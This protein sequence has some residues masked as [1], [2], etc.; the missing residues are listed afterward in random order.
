VP[1]PERSAP[2]HLLV[3]DD[4]KCTEWTQNSNLRNLPDLWTEHSDQ[5]K[6]IK[7]KQSVLPDVQTVNA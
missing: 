6:I 1:T 5:I 3:V 7:I 4:F 2:D